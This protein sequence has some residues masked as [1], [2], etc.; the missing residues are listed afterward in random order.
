[1]YVYPNI[2]DYREANRLSQ[3]QIAEILE[4][5]QTQ[6]SRWERGAYEIPCHVVVHLAKFYET[7]TDELLKNGYPTNKE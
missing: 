6:Y 7:T 3:K 4:T 1:M 5:T 2:K